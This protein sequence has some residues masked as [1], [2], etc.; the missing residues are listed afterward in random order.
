[1]Y[2]IRKLYS[3]VQP[4]QFIQGGGLVLINVNRIEF[5]RHLLLLI[6]I[7]MWDDS[8]IYCFS[9]ALMQLII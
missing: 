3:S 1:M 8:S 5:V 9:I 4:A 2:S 7:V 6:I